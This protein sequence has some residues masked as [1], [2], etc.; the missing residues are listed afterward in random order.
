MESFC[1][2]IGDKEGEPTRPAMHERRLDGLGELAQRELVINGIMDEDRIILA[3][4]PHR[5]L[6]SL[7]MRALGIQPPAHAA[8]RRER[9][10]NV[11]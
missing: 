6:V 5:A 1:G 7:H 4:Q 11:I 2:L 8:S 3:L 9:S 10:T